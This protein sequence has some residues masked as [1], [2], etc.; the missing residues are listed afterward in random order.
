LTLKL[1]RLRQGRVRRR[2]PQVELVL[3]VRDRSAG[4]GLVDVPV[5]R[6][7]SGRTYAGFSEC[8]ELNGILVRILRGTRWWTAIA[9][10]YG[11]A[12]ASSATLVAGNPARRQILYTRDHRGA[13]CR[14]DK[15]GRFPEHSAFVVQHLDAQPAAA[16]RNRN[17]S[18]NLAWIGAVAEGLR[19]LQSIQVDLNHVHRTGT[20]RGCV[21]AHGG[22][23]HHFVVRRICNGYCR[24][25]KCGR[26]HQN[27]SED[28]CELLETHNLPPI[29]KK[30][31]GREPSWVRLGRSVAELLNFSSQE[32]SATVGKAATGHFIDEIIRSAATGE[33]A[34]RA[35]AARR[36]SGA[37]G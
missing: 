17:R 1:D 10:R 4:Y 12:S 23:D 33:N 29:D 13:G 14:F 6:P 28:P 2:H 26:S 5:G 30:K 22:C 27:G 16:R 36:A 9:G 7:V 34:Q 32:F 19:G 21:H 37:R 15:D 25:P 11:I 8:R 3:Q 31:L 35:L 18:V 20:G 24:L